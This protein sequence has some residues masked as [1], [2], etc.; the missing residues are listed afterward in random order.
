MNPKPGVVLKAEAIRSQPE[1]EA[2]HPLN[3]GSLAYLRSLSIP[4][5]LQRIGLHLARLPS[6]KEPNEYHTH[7]FEEEFYYILSGRGAI[8]MDGVEQ[9]VGPGDFIAFPSPSVPHV[10]RNPYPGDLLYLVGGERRDFE[11]AEFPR[12]GKV[13]VRDTEAAYMVDRE[14]LQVIWRKE[15][16]APGGPDKPE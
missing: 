13:L 15:E 16:V 5:G 3:P 14:A 10:L 7:R 11:F 1:Y 4:A 6:G 9:E 8:L 12:H 2:R